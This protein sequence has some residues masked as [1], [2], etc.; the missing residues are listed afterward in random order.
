ML[1]E[2]SLRHLPDLRNL[3][4]LSTNLGAMAISLE[5]SQ[6][7]DAR[8][9]RSILAMPSNRDQRLAQ[10]H[11]RTL[12]DDRTSR[13]LWTLRREDVAPRARHRERDLRALAVRIL[14]RDDHHAVRRRHRRRRRALAI[15]DRHRRVKQLA[16]LHRVREEDA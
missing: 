6:L 4:L 8:D 7:T 3:R 9:D 10:R 13:C 5:L 14:E 11:Q 15:H 12:G 16:A 2:Y 1:T